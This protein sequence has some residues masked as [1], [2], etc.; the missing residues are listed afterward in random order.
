LSLLQESRLKILHFSHTV[1]TSLNG[2]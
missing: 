2:N 1:H